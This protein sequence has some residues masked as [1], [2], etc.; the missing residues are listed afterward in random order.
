[1]KFKDLTI[2]IKNITWLLLASMTL[3]ACNEDELDTVVAEVPVSAGSAD[4]SKYVAL[5]DSFAA[6]YTD[7]ALFQDGQENSYPMLM[8]EQFAAVG[9]NVLTVPWMKDNNG[10]LLFGPPPSPVVI[11][12]GRFWFNQAKQAPERVT[13]LPTTNALEK[14]NGAF[15]NLG[16]PGAKCIDLLNAGWGNPSGIPTQ[17][18]SPY[19]ARFASSSSSSILADALTQNP[20]FFSLW[21]GGNDA[22]GYAIAGG[23]PAV[24]PLTDKTVFAQKYGELIT[25]LTA[26][27]RKGVVANIPDLTVLPHFYLIKFNQ[28]KQSD[29]VHPV[30]QTS[31]VPALNASLYNK[32]NAAL[33]FLG[34]GD[35]IKPLA[36]TGNNPMLMVD[37]KLPNLSLQL[38]AVL[39]GG[40]ADETTATVLGQIFGQAR[41]TKPGEIIV[42]GAANRIGKA[43]TLKDDGVVSVVPDL[44][45]LGVTFP[46][47]DRYVLLPHEI[48]EI[49]EHIVSYNQ[50]IATAINGKNLAFVEADKMLSQLMTTGVSEDGYSLNGNYI[51]GGM[52]SLDGIHP[53]SRGYAYIANRFIDA[54]N[55]QYQ[56]TIKKKNIG[57]YRILY[58]KTPL[59][60]KH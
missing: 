19:Y 36:E 1:M 22:L 40:G 35:R 5:G 28:L 55:K 12:D 50:S 14:L 23:D 44:Q 39:M 7:G 53:T 31:L 16:V 47:P 2:M 30:T 48:A 33:S 8:S 6:G 13:D 38:K 52:F 42:F 37:E 51:F 4:F 57:V 25:Q 60:I 41:Q 26:N 11:Q 58:P 32:L 49:K 59:A 15:T 54:I 21:I 24:N 34:Q 43:P 10:G 20:T 45:Q 17:V 3:V 27:G 56:S 46:L 18:S 9:G 29:L